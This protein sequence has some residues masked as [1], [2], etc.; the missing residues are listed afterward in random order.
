[1][2]CITQGVVPCFMSSIMNST[3]SIT[4]MPIW[5]LEYVTTS[6]ASD[7]LGLLQDLRVQQPSHQLSHITALSSTNLVHHMRRT[8]K[9]YQN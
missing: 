2:L 4:N 9:L 3:G 7:D 5:R 1:M 6:T 8:T